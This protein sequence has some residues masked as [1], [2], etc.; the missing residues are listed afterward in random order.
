MFAPWVGLLGVH[1]HVRGSARTCYVTEAL[2]RLDSSPVVLTHSRYRTGIRRST[3]P[4]IGAHPTRDG[5]VPTDSYVRK[6]LT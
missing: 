1:I 3:S 4:T 6:L 2:D 5:L